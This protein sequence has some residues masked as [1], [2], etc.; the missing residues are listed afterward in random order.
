LENRL[1]A[2]DRSIWE[3]SVPGVLE[4]PPVRW[5]STGTFEFDL[6][7]EFK[8]AVVCMDGAAAMHVRPA[9]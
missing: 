9:T 4:R 1:S 6:L 2:E 7:V 5:S 3:Y 8:R